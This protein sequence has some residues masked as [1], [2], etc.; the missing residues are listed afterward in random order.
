VHDEDTGVTWKRF[1][2][3]KRREAP[4][5][6]ERGSGALQGEQI[7]YRRGAARLAAFSPMWTVTSW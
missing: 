3:A 5:D 6:V 2:T 1:F 7:K 4:I